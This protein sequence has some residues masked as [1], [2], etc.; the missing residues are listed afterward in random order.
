M[1]TQTQ[2]YSNHRRNYPL[3]HFVAAPLLSI[4]FV[5]AVFTFVK[6]PSVPTGMTAVLATGVLAALL[7]SRVMAVTVQDRLIRLE[8]THEL[9]GQ[10]ELLYE[11]SGLKVL[12]EFPLCNHLMLMQAQAKQGLAE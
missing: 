8:M 7:A 2:T 6:A 1:A 9:N 10:V 5:Y 11:P 4:F 3:F 12:M